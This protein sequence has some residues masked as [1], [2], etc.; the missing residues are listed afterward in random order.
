MTVFFAE[1]GDLSGRLRYINCGHLPGL[2]LRRD[3]T[4]EWLQSTGTV[5][6]LFKDWDGPAAECD[7]LLGDILVLYTDGVT[8]SSDAAGEEFGAHRLIE[9]L[10]RHREQSAQSIVASM[11]ADVQRFSGE[12]QHDDITLVVAKCQGTV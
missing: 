3:G 7:L 9:S 11:V 8:E 2:L 5:L 1:Y 10:G 4:V 12:E 6:G